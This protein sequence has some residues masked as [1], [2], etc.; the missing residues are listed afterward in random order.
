M[1]NITV[2][3][4][5]V[6]GNVAD[7]SQMN[8]NFTDIINGTSDGT[9]DFSISAITCAGTATFN[10]STNI[11]GAL[12]ISGAASGF[13]LVPLGGIVA[14]ASNITG[15]HSIPATGTVD[16]AGWQLC[17]GAAIPGGNSLSGSVPTLNDNRFLAGA[18]TAGVADGANSITLTTSELPAHT[19]TGPSHTHTMP[20]HSHSWS[21]T[22]STHS[23]HTHTGPSHTHTMPTHTHSFSATSG[24]TGL[25][26]NRDQGT[27]GTSTSTGTGIPTIASGSY[28]N[29]LGLASAEHTHTVSGTTGST[30]PGDT[31]ASGTGNTGSGG[32]HS[33]T[34]SGTTGST[35]PGDTNASGTGNTGS[36]GSGSAFDNRPR[37]LTCQYLIR[38]K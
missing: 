9:K 20:T 4:T 12:N 31:N 33:H 37:Y 7:A 11:V 18:S 23:G 1:A 5:F 19:H 29:N 32:S 36:T 38:V 10:G 21:G 27:I 6:N 34:V 14:I 17:D 24:S 28:V 3:H 26:I 15:S 13:G 35:D 2:T 30:D 16:S 8:T 25:S 22:T